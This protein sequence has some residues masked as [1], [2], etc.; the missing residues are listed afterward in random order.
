[1]SN[2]PAQ[3][4]S[5]SDSPKESEGFF[6]FSRR[7]STAIGSS[8]MKKL[9]HLKKI[10]T[11]DEDAQYEFIYHS[12]QFLI[13]LAIHLIHTF[14]GPISL[15][16]IFK[17]FGT[18]LCKNMHFRWNYHY[19]KE[20][21]THVCIILNLAFCIAFPE[22]AFKWIGLVVS[23]LAVIALKNSF[24]SIK[25][26]YYSQKKWRAMKEETLERSF[27]DSEY[28]A[29]AWYSIPESV[30]DSELEKS[31]KRQSKNPH[32][33]CFMFET[34]LQEC[35]HNLLASFQIN[36]G[37]ETV[38]EGISHSNENP[39][40][41]LSVLGKMLIK[42]ADKKAH[43]KFETYFVLMLNIVYCILPFTTVWYINGGFFEEDSNAL[44]IV[45]AVINS[46][47]SCF[48]GWRLLMFVYIGIC[49]FRRKKIMIDEC[50]AMISDID[51]KDTVW[52]VRNFPSADMH[53]LRTIESWYTLR[54]AS[55]D[56]GRKFTYRIFA[57]SSFVLPL[58]CAMVALFLLQAFGI[59]GGASS[60]ALIS[61]LFFT[62]VMLILIIYMTFS[63]MEL[64]RAF[65]LHRDLILNIVGH[66]MKDNNYNEENENVLA[67]I[68][69]LQYL[70]QKLEQ[71]EIL[72]PVMIMG[73]R[74]DSALLAKVVTVLISGVLGLVQMM[75]R[76]G[77]S[78]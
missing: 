44:L 19:I 24:L 10:K 64:N 31:F 46:I 61:L 15:P 67:T 35:Y 58:S 18:N 54:T 17:I 41:P 55:L 13:A 72:R 20:I 2:S 12:N 45:I 43:Y 9:S 38:H 74:L 29:L 11:H 22:L 49:D 42:E 70:V 48:E 1:M 69:I 21:F 36:L 32:E 65:S 26:G 23:V 75:M 53:D 5:S 66:I 68:K 39:C 28:L 40:Y 30:I 57:Y 59:I 14:L 27:L 50:T 78:L 16:I 73:I 25:Y 34:P 62:I 8:R 77:T 51:I 71:D 60:G 33:L 6:N 63:G 47:E 76:S 7:G 3:V 52:F 37:I 56:F 4:S